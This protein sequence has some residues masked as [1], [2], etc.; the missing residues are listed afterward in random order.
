MRVIIPEADSLFL[1]STLLYII[2]YTSFAV[3]EGDLT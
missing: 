3:R 1:P 2:Q